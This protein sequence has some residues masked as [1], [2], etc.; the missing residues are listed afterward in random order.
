MKKFF[1]SFFFLLLPSLVFA[2]KP[3]AIPSL[4]LAGL[5]EMVSQNRGKLVVLNFF[6]TWCPPCRVEIREMVQLRERVDEGKVMILG[7]SVDENTAPLPAFVSKQ[8]I[9]YPVYIVDRD[10][11][12][13]FQVSTIPHNVFYTKDGKLALSQSGIADTEMLESVVQTL[14]EQN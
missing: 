11:A 13:A 5:T 14:L 1:F 4:D 3:A 9:N 7:L 10:V 8:Q 2:G 12:R 6:A